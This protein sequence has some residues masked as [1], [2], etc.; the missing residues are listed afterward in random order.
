[1]TKD[2]TLTELYQANEVER[3][4]RANHGRFQGTVSIKKNGETRIMC[5]QSVGER[6]GNSIRVLDRNTGW[7]NI[8]LASVSQI[9]CGVHSKTFSFKNSYRS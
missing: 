6:R 9:N 5:V 8:N 4:L 7:R 1:M 2:Y 3:N